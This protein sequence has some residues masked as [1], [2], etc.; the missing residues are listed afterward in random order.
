MVVIG[1]PA[2]S[3]HSHVQHG[4]RCTALRS[5]QGADRRPPATG[6]RRAEDEGMSM[7]FM[8]FSFVAWPG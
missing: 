2:T 5:E 3:G 6:P 4:D 8:V 7:M 1:Y